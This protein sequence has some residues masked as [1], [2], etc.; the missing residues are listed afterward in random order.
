MALIKCTECGHM[1]SDKAV[2]CPKCGCPLEKKI[3]CEE[4]GQE[5]ST[6]DNVCANCGRSRTEEHLSKVTKT[7]IISKSEEKSGMIKYAI[8]II[9][10][11]AISVIACALLKRTYPPHIETEVI[12]SNEVGCCILVATL[13]ILLFARRFVD[14]FVLCIFVPLISFLCLDNRELLEHG[15]GVVVHSVC[16]ISIIAA[17]Y[18]GQSPTILPYLDSISGW[19]ATI[20]LYIAGVIGYLGIVFGIY[21]LMHHLGGVNMMLIEILLSALMIYVAK[22]ISK[23]TE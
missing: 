5:L 9:I 18:K 19:G 8:A 21:G 1:V 3:Y 10:Y 22:K 16:I 4:C 11:V 6:K 12:V 20:L 7:E 14:R 13:L 17:V 2:E 15:A 23:K